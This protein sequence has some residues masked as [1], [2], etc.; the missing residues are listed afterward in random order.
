[1][2]YATATQAAIMH[3]KD[4]TSIWVSRKKPSHTAGVSFGR[5]S[6]FNTDPPD[7]TGAVNAKA[8]PVARSYILGDGRIVGVVKSAGS[9][10]IHLVGAAATL[11]LDVRICSK[12]KMHF[13]L[14]PKQSLRDHFLLASNEKLQNHTQLHLGREHTGSRLVRK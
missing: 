7:T 11:I 6:D 8:A 14:F 3:H 1:M 13:Q 10:R 2:C 4:E 9:P 5:N 12:T